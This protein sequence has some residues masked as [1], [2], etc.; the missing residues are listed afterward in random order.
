MRLSTSTSKNS[1]S[2]YI[3]K[4]TFEDGKRS[5]KIVE[6][7]GTAKQIAEKYPGVDPETWARQRL[8]KLNAAE[9]KANREVIAYLSPTKRIAKEEQRSVGGGYLF[10]ADIYYGLGLGEICKQIASRHKFSFDLDQI[11]SRLIFGRILEPASKR[12]THLFSQTLLEASS[13]DLHQIYRALEVIAAECDFIQS[14]LYKNS[15]KLTTRNDAILFYD[16]TNFFFE[17]EQEDG[18]KQY[19][20]SKENRPNPIVQMGLFMDGDGLPLAF[21]IT[22]G[23]TNEQTTLIPLEKQVLSDFEHSRFIVCTDAGLSSLVNRRFNSTKSRSFITT[24]SVKK[25]K[26]HLKDWAT[27]SDGWRL[28]EDGPE[29]DIS[30]IEPGQGRDLVFF[31]ERWIKENGFEQRLIVTFSPKY[32]DYQRQIRDRQI[33]RAAKLVGAHPKKIAQPRQNDYKRFIEVIPITDEGQMADKTV[34]RLDESRIAGEE[35]YDG[36]YAVCTDLEDSAIEIAAINKR[37]WQ[38]EECFRIMKQEFRARPAYLSRDDRITAHFATCFIALIVF[39]LLE[40]R[41]GDAYTPTEIID[42]LKS[43][44]FLKVKGEG[45]VPLYRRTSLTDA[46]HEAFGF[47]TDTQ[48]VTTASM[49][50]IARKTKKKS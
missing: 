2:F 20:P 4:S 19:G 9:K 35:V 42:G 8:E 37:R 17:I 47:R 29:Y 18:I 33:Q 13:F 1:T 26:G 41:L 49:R 12:A 10:L 50:K 6:K 44:D 25:L 34:Y 39:R 5:T 48:I 3:I 28:A 16:C 40:K 38:I 30:Q 43:M 46:L 32:R 31:K 21:S 11:L 27:D 23:N 7:L 36:L 24:Q 45:Y 14:A 22:A 15:K